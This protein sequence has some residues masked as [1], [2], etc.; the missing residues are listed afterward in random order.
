[1]T[2]SKSSWQLGWEMH[3]QLVLL[4][5]MINIR[6]QFSQGYKSRTEHIL[7]SDFMSPGYF[8]IAAGFTYAK[9]G[10]PF[11]ITL[12]PLGGNIVTVLNDML[13]EDGRYGVPCRRTGH[14]K[15]RLLGRCLLRPG[16][17]KEGVA[18]L[19]LRPLFL[20]PLH[21]TGQSH[22]QVGEH[23]RDKDNQIHL[24]QTLRTALLPQGGQYGTPVPILVH[25]RAEIRIQE[26]ITVPAATGRKPKANHGKE[27]ERQHT[28]PHSPVGS[29]RTG[30]GDRSLRRPQ[31][32]GQ[33]AAQSG[34]ANSIRRA[35]R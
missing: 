28:H 25:D 10:S 9:A 13:P 11:K 27:F 26:Q 32:R 21:R 12:S 23:V 3:R 7:V 1:M 30:R 22:G 15:T 18:T 20:S 4:R 6:S 17:R 2:N 5:L 29:A 31:Q 8:D 24:H 35:A 34:R 19:P 33:E 14:R 16:V